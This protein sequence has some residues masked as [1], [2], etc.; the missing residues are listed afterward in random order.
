[1]S[2]QKALSMKL[3]F[4]YEQGRMQIDCSP[5]LAASAAGP[6]SRFNCLAMPAGDCSS[7]AAGELRIK[8]TASA[9]QGGACAEVDNLEAAVGLLSVPASEGDF[10]M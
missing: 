2:L 4:G 6:P 9:K 1:M 10:L 5:L 8:C 3:H 7:Y